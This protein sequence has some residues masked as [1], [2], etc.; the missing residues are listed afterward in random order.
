MSLRR[1]M[2][3]LS[4]AAVA[5]AVVLSAFACYIAVESSMRNRLDHQLKAF[6]G[7]VAAVARH[8]PTPDRPGKRFRFPGRLPRAHLEAGGD[9]ALFSA[10]GVIH[11]SPEDH[12]AFSITTRDLAVA[13]GTAPAYFRNGTLGGTDVRIYVTAAGRGRAVIIE[14]SLTDLESTL[15]DLAVILIVIVLAGVALAGL[16]GLLVARAAAVPVHILRRAAEHVGSTGDLSRRIETVGDDDLGRL[17][18]S[19]NTMLAALEESHRAQRQLIGDASH[20]LRTPVA[21][22]RTNLEVLLR[23]PDLDLTERTPLLEDLIEQSAEIGALIEDLLESARNGDESDAPESL[24]LDALVSWE[25]E[26]CAARHPHIH[27]ES[28]LEPCVVAGRET[29]LS[30]AVVNLL[31]NAVKWSPPAA[32]VEVT[33]ADGELSVRDHGPGFGEEDLPHVFDRFYRSPV[34]RSVPGS[35]LGLSIVR[36]V[37]GEHGGTVRARN[38]PDGG[39]VVAFALPRTSTDERVGVALTARA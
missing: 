30:R 37:V 14:Q 24:R 35:G 38:A 17:S 1:R 31:D 22:L 8:S 39:A 3:L 27:F 18:A 23:N 5:L 7:T 20:E 32:T 6:A 28:Q 15:H 13:R 36:K 16:L 29:R 21:S 4:A 26:R 2:V 10:T 12:T 11:K 33:L 19:F 34:A 9:A 25:I